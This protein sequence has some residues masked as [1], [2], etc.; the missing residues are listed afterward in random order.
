[1]TMS[2]PRHSGVEERYAAAAIFTMALHASQVDSGS[3]APETG[4][5]VDL[6]TTWG[7]DESG[8]Q[9]RFA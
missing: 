4:G 7:Y 2:S 6:T 1:M 9:S 5:D 8:P 3:A